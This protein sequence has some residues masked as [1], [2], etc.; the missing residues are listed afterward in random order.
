MSII[1]PTHTHGGQIF[2]FPSIE[3]PWNLKFEQ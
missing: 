1:N 3:E 2:T